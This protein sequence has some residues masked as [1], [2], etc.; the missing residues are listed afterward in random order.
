[1]SAGVNEEFGVNRY[2]TKYKRNKQM[3]KR[4]NKL[5]DIENRLV[6]GGGFKVVE[7]GTR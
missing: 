3:E 5:T 6:V 2:T 4:E 7:M 1:M